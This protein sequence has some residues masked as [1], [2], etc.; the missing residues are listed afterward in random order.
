MIEQAARRG[1]DDVDAA[2]KRVLLRPHADAAVDGRAG[3]RRVHGQVVQI[4][5]DLRGQLARR[6]EDERLAS[7]RAAGRSGD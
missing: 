4:L 6:R 1:D 2:A 3:H 7:S 5:E